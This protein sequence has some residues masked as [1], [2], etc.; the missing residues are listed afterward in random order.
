MNPRKFNASD[1]TLD[2]WEGIK[3]CRKKPIVVHCI[4]MNFPEGFEVET[5]EGIMSG[6]AGDF[7]IFGI[8]GEKYPCDQEIFHKTYDIIEE[9]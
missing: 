5:M 2:N 9:E 3:K 1:I 8:N 6:K 4:Q 7:L